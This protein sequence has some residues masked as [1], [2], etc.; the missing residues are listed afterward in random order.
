MSNTA[1]YHTIIRKQFYEII[2]TE[3][4]LRH[5]LH[6]AARTGL[7]K[8]FLIKEQGSSICPEIMWAYTYKTL[9]I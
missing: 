3:A 5:C 1:H 8:K 4:Y 7:I 9:Y 6:C 2:L